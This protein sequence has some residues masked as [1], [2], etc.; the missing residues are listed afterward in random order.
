[1]YMISHIYIYDITYIIYKQ[2]CI[3]SV[4]PHECILSTN[5]VYILSI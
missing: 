2:L 1:M 3:S 4:Y 5:D